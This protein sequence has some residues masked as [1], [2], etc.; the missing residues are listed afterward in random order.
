MV[1][2]STVTWE[3]A[4]DL[5]GCDRFFHIPTTK[6]PDLVIWSEEEKEVHLVELTVPHE[7]NIS[8]AHERKENRYEVLVGEC[9]EAGWKAKHFPV[10]VGCRGYIATSI[11]KWMKEAGLCTKK[12]KILTKA[13][14]ETVEK[15]SHWIWVKREDTSWS[16]LWLTIQAHSWTGKE[17]S[18]QWGGSVS[19]NSCREEEP[20]TT[21]HS[22]LMIF[23]PESSTWSIQQ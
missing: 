20:E 16:E 3:E 2:Q 12:R 1:S 19:H 21:T 9:E 22:L 8:S 10:E 13:L 23:T 18:H 4:A 7:D 11:T 14:Q 15:A 17:T 6:K 5:K